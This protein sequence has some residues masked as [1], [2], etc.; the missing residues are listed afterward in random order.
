MKII[1]LDIDGVLNNADYYRGKNLATHQNEISH[2]DSNNIHALNRIIDNTKAEIVLSSA[3]RLLKSIEEINEL[4]NLVGIKGKVIDVTESLHYKNTYELAP[5][6]LEIFKWI[7]DY[8]KTL[9][10]G[11]ENYIIIDDE[12]DILDI[13]EKHF[14]QID[15][16]VGLSEKDADLV[17][18][19]LNS[20][21]VPKENLP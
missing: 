6:G 21:Q 5:R 2:F 12:D 15:D 18:E 8:H 1:F 19:F 11:L 7:R 14:L 3:W 10:G 9:K 16:R 17:I 13:Q 20:Y 4:F